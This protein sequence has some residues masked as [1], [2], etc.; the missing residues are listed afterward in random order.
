MNGIGTVP[1]VTMDCRTVL[2][3]YLPGIV[4]SDDRCTL[5]KSAFF[6]LLLTFF[7]LVGNPL[8]A[9]CK[10]ANRYLKANLYTFNAA[11]SLTSAKWMKLPS[12]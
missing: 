2:F 10:Q 1:C 7:P 11:D 6:P 5:P 3:N 9:L 12:N 8:I 4:C